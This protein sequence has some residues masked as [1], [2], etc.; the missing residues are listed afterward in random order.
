MTS[1]RNDV[2]DIIYACCTDKLRSFREGRFER[3]SQSLENFRE[4]F[5]QLHS[6][7]MLVENAPLDSPAMDVGARRVSTHSE[8]RLELKPFP[9]V[10]QMRTFA[11]MDVELNS[12]QHRVRAM[13]Q[14]TTSS[15]PGAPMIGLG[16]TIPPSMPAVRDGYRTG[17]K[18]NRFAEINQ[19]PSDVKFASEMQALPHVP[20]SMRPTKRIS[21]A[22]EQDC[23]GPIPASRDPSLSFDSR[24]GAYQP[25]ERTVNSGAR[26]SRMLP[27]TPFGMPG[28]TEPQ[29]E[30]VHTMV[31]EL[32]SVSDFRIYQLYNVSR[33]VTP[34]DAGRMAKYVQRCCETSTMVRSVESSNPTLLLTFLEDTRVAFIAQNLTKDV[35]IRFFAQFLEHDAE[36]VKRAIL[37]EVSAPVCFMTM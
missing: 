3:V 28:T 31:Q 14:A 35:A 34:G 6:C 2:S 13:E 9:S 1:L 7:L 17:I 18:T 29:H 23:G 27:V 15:S 32:R 10:G 24:W 4:L 5:D 11:H 30:Q 20:G 16:A 19:P 21:Y 33:L 22:H 8:V 25:V 12:T 37:C 26:D 36:H